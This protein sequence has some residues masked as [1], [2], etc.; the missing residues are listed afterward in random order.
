ML[1]VVVTFA[2][3]TQCDYGEINRNISIA[4]IGFGVL[5][6]LNALLLLAHKVT[7][8]QHDLLTIITMVIFPCVVFLNVGYVVFARSMVESAVFQEY[9]WIVFIVYI[10]GIYLIYYRFLKNPSPNKVYVI[11]IVTHMII[12]VSL[13][14]YSIPMLIESLRCIY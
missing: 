13:V 8:R 1:S 3:F 12:G 11:D 14:V 10:I 9:W 5:F 7:A 2:G 6:I 4:I